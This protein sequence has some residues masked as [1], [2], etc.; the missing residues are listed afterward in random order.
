MSE[1]V[2][3]TEFHPE[4]LY[5]LVQI[6]EDDLPEVRRCFWKYKW[7]RPDTVK[8]VTLW[9]KELYDSASIDFVKIQTI[10]KKAPVWYGHFDLL[11]DVMGIHAYKPVDTRLDLVQW[12]RI[13][14][15]AL[16]YCFKIWDARK[17]MTSVPEC[18]YGYIR[19]VESLGFIREGYLREA[20]V[21]NEKPVDMLLYAIL[22][23]EF[24]GTPSTQEVKDVKSRKQSRSRKQEKRSGGKRNDKK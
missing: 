6:E 15:M 2:P 16:D 1:L 10:D 5:E 8:S 4:P 3:F 14:S 24:Y 22:R 18:F 9:V 20:Q 12:G 11:G 13:G 7:L 17:I 23:H 21:F 19:M